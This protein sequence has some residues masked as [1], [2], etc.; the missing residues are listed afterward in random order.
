MK[1]TVQSSRVFNRQERYAL[2][3]DVNKCIAWVAPELQDKIVARNI[4]EFYPA[5]QNTLNSICELPHNDD[6]VNELEIEEVV[7]NVVKGFGL[8][9]MPTNSSARNFQR[10]H[11]TLEAWHIVLSTIKR[12]V[13]DMVVKGRVRVAK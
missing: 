11:T 13:D 4:S 3:G 1:V 12:H 5:L 10:E 8:H 9:E 7:Y 2:E 6:S